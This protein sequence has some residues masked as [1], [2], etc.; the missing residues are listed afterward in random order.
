MGKVLLAYAPESLFRATVEAG[1]D[2][3]TAHT[4]IAPGH[5]RRALAEIR[6]TGIAYAREEL[7]VGTLSVAS[8]VLDP[9]GG[10]VAALSVTLR[11]GRGDLRRL[12]PAVHTAA[13]SVSREL[14]ERALLARD[15]SDRAPW[16]RPGPAGPPGG[17]DAGA[18]GVGGPGG[19]QSSA[20][21][22]TASV[23]GPPRGAP[24][25]G[26]WP[27]TCQLRAASTLRPAPVASRSVTASV[28]ERPGRLRDAEADHV[29]HPRR[30]GGLVALDRRLGTLVGRR[31][32][33]AQPDRAELD[34]RRAR[35]EPRCRV[36]EAH[37][38]L[39]VLD[40]VPAPAEGV[41]R[42]QGEEPRGLRLVLGRLEALAHEVRQCDGRRLGL[43]GPRR[44]R[45]RA[46]PSGRPRPYRRTREHPERDRAR[47]TPARAPPQAAVPVA[48]NVHG[49]PPE[50]IR[51]PRPDGGG[52]Y[53]ID[54]APLPPVA[55]PRYRRAPGGPC[56]GGH[57]GA[58]ARAPPAVPHPL[59][60][61]PP[62]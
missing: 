42:G 52:A 35:R 36:L 56:R 12:G 20:S 25:A 34:Q 37:R 44:C 7:T 33:L 29:R 22:T 49:A 32:G 2:R 28:P 11:S 5:L 54:D 8:A 6:R 13:I 47:H 48:S 19:Q 51:G 18:D 43:G 62:P 21:V 16:S 9:D 27:H 50:T 40:L 60:R 58:G 45:R 24:A 55:V 59:P 41:V 46:P 38:P 1:L 3:Y 61:R 4:I 31:A 10:P 15:R 26:S 23:T 39:A 53:S 30:V 57:T 17:A 14:Q